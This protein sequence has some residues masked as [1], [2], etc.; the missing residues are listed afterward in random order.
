MPPVD[1]TTLTGLPAPYWFVQFFKILGFI[2]HS[3]P[4]HHWLVGLPLALL[5][6][7]IGGPNAKRFARRLLAQL[8]IL[9]ALG[10]NFGIVPL[11]F[12]QTAYPKAFYPATILMAW[13]WLGIL[14]M[15]LIA[16]YSLYRVSAQASEGK[17]WRPV[18]L[19]L[20][21]S[22]LLVA[23]G[24]IFSSAWSFMA[25][26]ESWPEVW[27]TKSVAAAASGLGTH[28]RDPVVYFRFAQIIGLAFL[29]LSCWS[30]FDVWFL[31]TGRM[32][33]PASPKKSE[34]QAAPAAASP[35]IAPK[36]SFAQGQKATA[37]PKE[38]YSDF[39]DN[40]HLSAKEKKR[41]RKLRDR[42]KLTEEE[43]IKALDYR[44]PENGDGAAEGEKAAPKPKKEKKPRV[45]RAA[46]PDSYRRWVLSFAACMLW[47]GVLLGGGLLWFYYYQFLTPETPNLAWLFASPGK[48]LPMATL[49]AIGL[50][51][52][53]MIAGRLR[54]LTGKR[55]VAA[56]FVC[57]ALTLGF[58]AV[59]RQKIQN[60][61]L[62]DYFDVSA[63]PLEIQWSPLFAFLATFVVGL[64]V[65]VW[66]I[67]VMAKC[68]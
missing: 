8:P 5:L 57:E 13:H 63:L 62:T 42:G 49:T 35:V 20:F 37:A 21:A 54:R 66:M 9:M 40:P 11:L 33:V 36:Y 7:L 39:M 25:S 45:E 43:E 44:G 50:F 29:T 2:L 59:T 64:L 51:L 23:V 19:G 65:I 12:I 10:I 58:F 14:P 60:A 17:R 68:G 18:L 46:D 27:R 56:L 28:W 52:P 53:V 16:Y 34:P 38:S 1:S 47:F 26:P 55:F 67:R 22:L 15:V 61:E 3:I 32:S 24:L 30:L 41:L 31:D 4:M 48:Y 6:L